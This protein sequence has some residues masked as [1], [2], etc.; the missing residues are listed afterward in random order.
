M[1]KAS[2]FRRAA[3]I[4]RSLVGNG[5]ETGK[6][7]RIEFA[8]QQ[9]AD[10]VSRKRK[11]ER[12]ADLAFMSQDSGMSREE[13]NAK[14]RDFRALGI[15]TIGVHRF[16]ACGLYKMEGEQALETIGLIKESA[17]LEDDLKRGFKRMGLGEV[18]LEDLQPGIESFKALESRLLTADEKKRI[19]AKA[20]YLHPETMDDAETE[21]LALDMEFSRRILRCNH[22]GYTAFHFRDKSIPERREFIC[23]EERRRILRK[24]NSDESNAILDDKLMTYEALSGFYGRDMAAVEGDG[25]YPEFCGF[26]TKNDMAVIKPRFESLGKGIRLMERPSDEDMRSEFRN[27]VDEYGSFLMEGFIDAAEELRALNPDS[28]NTV[29]IIAWFD[30]EKTAIQSASMRIG[31]AGSFVDNVGAGGLTVSVDR[32]TGVIDSD[33]IDERGFRYETHPETGVRFRGCRLPAWD[34]ALEVVRSVSGRIDGAKYVGWDLAC[35][36]DHNWVI[37]EGNGKTGFY[38]AQAPKDRGVR[39]E[40]LETIGYDQNG[41]LY[42]DVELNA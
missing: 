33:A 19:A 12:D 17:D 32:E 40:F 10:R 23:D 13:L 1:K 28:V 22:E 21:D 42:E 38:G 2:I 5:A 6:A 29:R 3:G 26:F 30:G 11:R 34:R 36:R 20:A 25:D 39:R 27:L 37:V 14:L 9:V 7:K 8:Q 16:R 31:H 18:S 41:L 35:T 15:T 24:L 4:A